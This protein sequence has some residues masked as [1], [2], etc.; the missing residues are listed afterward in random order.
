MGRLFDI[1]QRQEDAAMR[2]DW[3]EWCSYFA[4]NVDARSPSYDVKDQAAFLDA[5]RA[6]I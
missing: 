2:E 1:I 5:I 3:D 6:Q 4:N